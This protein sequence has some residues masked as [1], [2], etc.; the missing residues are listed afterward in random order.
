MPQPSILRLI[1]NA[2]ALAAAAAAIG[3]YVMMMDF[4]TGFLKLFKKMGTFRNR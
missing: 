3:E 2:A 4:I 1:R